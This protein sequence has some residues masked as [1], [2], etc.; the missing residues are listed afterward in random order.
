MEGHWG[1]FSRWGD[2]N[3]SLMQRTVT[4]KYQR[5]GTE[6]NDS[7]KEVQRTG[8]SCL[9]LIEVGKDWASH[10]PLRTWASQ[11]LRRPRE[12][13]NLSPFLLL[14]WGQSLHGWVLFSSPL[15]QCSQLH[16]HTLSLCGVL[17]W[18]RKVRKCQ[19]YLMRVV[20]RNACGFSPS[21]QAA[22]SLRYCLRSNTRWRTHA[23][24]PCTT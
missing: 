4:E 17:M 7:T 10:T 19:L 1:R 20:R 3:S 13:L 2:L 9:S 12:L 6:G 11:Q 16:C 18:A 8:G 24:T 22:A 15:P 23:H 14:V 5:V 21:T